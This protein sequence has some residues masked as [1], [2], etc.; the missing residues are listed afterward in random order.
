MNPP[1]FKCARTSKDSKNFNEELERVFDLMH[2]VDSKRVHLVAYQLTSISRTCFDQWKEGRYEDAP[3]ANWACLKVAFLGHFFPRE[4]KDAKVQ[5]FLAMNQDSLIVHEYWLEFTQ[6]SHYSL[7]IFKD[8]RSKMSLFIAGLH[9]LSR[10]EG[11]AVMLISDMDISM[12]MFY[13]QQV[14]EEKM[15]DREEFINKKAKIGNE[16]GR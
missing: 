3:P 10:V 9:S 16:S 15:R 13:V 7:D 4:L 8:M 6:L 11:R 5:E 1:S 2:V 14:E 12:L